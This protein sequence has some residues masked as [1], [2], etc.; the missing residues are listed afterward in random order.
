MSLFFLGQVREIL[1]NLNQRSDL[2]Y[3]SPLGKQRAV[4]LYTFTCTYFATLGK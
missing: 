2:I 3:V 1:K 4:V